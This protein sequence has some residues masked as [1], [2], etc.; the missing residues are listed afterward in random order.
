MRIMIYQHKDYR[1]WLDEEIKRRRKDN[2]LLST[3]TFAKKLGISQALLSL[4]LSGKRKLT[5]KIAQEIG[6]RL[7]LSDH[8]LSYLLLIIA[9][10]NANAADQ[11]KFYANE[12]KKFKVKKV[13]PQ[14]TS[15]F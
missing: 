1:S 6:D 13:H 15:Q 2:P 10:E 8:E 4:I 3:T 9:H 14:S 11:K 7:K 12:L 5:P